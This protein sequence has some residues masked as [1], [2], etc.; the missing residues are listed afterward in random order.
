VKNKDLYAE[1]VVDKIDS[2][3]YVVIQKSIYMLELSLNGIV[4]K[5]F[6]LSLRHFWT[7]LL[8]N[9]LKFFSMHID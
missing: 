2:C 7:F 6:R 4:F 8:F 9:M 1:L 3:N 5:I